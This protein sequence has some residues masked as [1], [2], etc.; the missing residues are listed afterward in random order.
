M[1]FVGRIGRNP[2]LPREWRENFRYHNRGRETFLQKCFGIGFN[3]TGTKS[4]GKAMRLLGYRTTSF[5]GPLTEQVGRGEVDAALRVARDF[6]GFEDWPWPLIYKELDRVFPGSKFILTMRRDART[7]LN[8]LMRHAERT[9]PT[10]FREI[11]YGYASP[12]HREA[13]H[14][15]L[16]ER[17][18]A[19]VMAH[20]R[21]RPGQ[22]RVLCWERGD[23]WPELCDFLGRPRPE[24]PF[25]HENRAPPI[26]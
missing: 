13:H 9:G 19:E 10:I 22:L 14:I 2:P 11:A 3:K 26:E 6:D 15:G 18:A 17:H 20:F 1:T 8:S 25:P 23:G 24:Q 5:D 16:Y 7:W 21:D 12:Q 4:L